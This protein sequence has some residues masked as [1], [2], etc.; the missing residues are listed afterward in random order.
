MFKMHKLFAFAAVAAI[1]LASCEP[2]TPVDP[3]NFSF[4]TK[5]GKEKGIDLKLRASN[6]LN[7]DVL[8]VYK[9]YGATDQI[10][11]R[12]APGWSVSA[13]LTFKL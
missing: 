1:T 11:S 4:T 8:S 6:M 5:L 7:D 10:F 12:Y 2:T 3:N 13:G 9:S